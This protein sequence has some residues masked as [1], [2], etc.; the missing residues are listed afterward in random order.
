MKNTKKAFLRRLRL[1]LFFW[2]PAGGAWEVAE[3]YEGFFADRMAEGKTE[4]EVCREFG[5]PRRVASTILKEEGRNGKPLGLLAVLGAFLIPWLFRYGGGLPFF[6]TVPYDHY[7]F[8]AALVLLQTPLLWRL[9]RESAYPAAPPAWG[10]VAALGIIPLALWGACYGFINWVSR[11]PASWATVQGVDGRFYSLGA[12]DAGVAEA[13]ELIMTAVLLLALLRAWGRSLWYLV[14]AA[15]CIGA[16]A[17]VERILVELRRVN[18]AATAE[19][20]GRELWWAPPVA[21]LILAWGGAALTAFLV[22][23]GGERYGRAA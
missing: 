17:A 9:W 12:L 23:K 3:D 6:H 8:M 21:Y 22:W 16:Y 18:I 15:H 5:E 13:A 1:A 19:A 2:M 7:Y 4:A 11:Q 20:I 10:W 14:P